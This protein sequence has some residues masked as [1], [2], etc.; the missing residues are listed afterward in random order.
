M[1]CSNFSEPEDRL[2]I[3]VSG[4]GITKILAIPKIASFSGNM[5]ATAVYDA[6]VEWNLCDKVQLM[7]FDTTASNTGQNEAACTHLEKKLNKKMLHLAC[8]HHI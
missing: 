3:L 6:I 7:C 8:R 1:L 5:Q 4:Q 2:A